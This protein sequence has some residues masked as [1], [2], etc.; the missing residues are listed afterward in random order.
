M[1]SRASAQLPCKSS[2]SS[3]LSN[4]QS[5]S[6][7]SHAW[8]SDAHAYTHVMYWR[9]HRR[10]PRI[11]QAGDPNHV[12]NI[13]TP[14][15]NFK[16]ARATLI[17]SSLCRAS[18]NIEFWGSGYLCFARG[19]C[20]I[21]HVFLAH[22]LFHFDLRSLQHTHAPT[23]AYT[24]MHIHVHIRKRIR[25]QP[26]S[27]S[28]SMGSSFT[29]TCFFKRFR[30]IACLLLAWMPSPAVKLWPW[31]VRVTPQAPSSLKFGKAMALDL[32]REL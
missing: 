11:E 20:V 6:A 4:S 10:S 16:V 23:H 29:P 1:Q 9:A 28:G 3:S 19:G 13:S 30:G 2:L 7:V 22:L 14:I 25:T 8:A 21:S 32:S 5:L 12:R 27:L 18:S 17:L 15:P 31:A 24:Y 26:L